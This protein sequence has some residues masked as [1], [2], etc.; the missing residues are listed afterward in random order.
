MSTRHRLGL[1]HGLRGSVSVLHKK[2][3]AM[4]MACAQIVLFIDVIRLQ[5]GLLFVQPLGRAG[6][7]R[8]CSIP[9]DLQ[10]RIQT[11]GACIYQNYLSEKMEGVCGDRN[12]CADDRLALSSFGSGVEGCGRDVTCCPL[13]ASGEKNAPST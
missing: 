6:V 5:K 11:E 7:T 13:P 4:A 8:S 10:T 2:A 1:H 9:P 3:M 12:D